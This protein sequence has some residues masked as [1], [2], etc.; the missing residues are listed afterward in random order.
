MVRVIR[1]GAGVSK[2]CLFK[3]SSS[4]CC[5]CT[6]TCS[7]SGAFLIFFLLV[8]HYDISIIP[9]KGSSSGRSSRNPVVEASAE[10]ADMWMLKISEPL[11]VP[12]KVL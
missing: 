6:C 11:R 9:C 5:D 2:Q 10:E 12:T 8:V 3:F 1:G 7:G 4:C